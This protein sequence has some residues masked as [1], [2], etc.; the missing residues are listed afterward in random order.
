MGLPWVCH[1]FAIGLPWVCHG[2]AMGLPWV[3]HGFA[4]GWP[5][6]CHRFAR[7]LPSV[8]QG[9][10]RG[11]PS[12]EVLDSPGWDYSGAQQLLLPWRW[13]HWL[14][15][16]LSGMGWRLSCQPESEAFS[17]AGL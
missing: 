4:M 8:C 5:W 10:A 17:L 7:G 11:L 3:C 1:G 6:V 16:G 2:F 13:W 14:D 15:V 9:F 12:T